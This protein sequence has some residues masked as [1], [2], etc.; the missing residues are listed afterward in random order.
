[1]LPLRGLAI[2]YGC[3]LLPVTPMD[4][5]RR[6][7]E[8]TTAAHLV[9][10]RDQRITGWSPSASVMLGMVEDAALGRHC[11]DVVRGRD[12]SGG[13][14]CRARCPAIQALREGRL[15]HASA[16]VMDGPVGAGPVACD[17]VALPAPSDGALITLSER[18]AGPPI[19]AEDGVSAGSAHLLASPAGDRLR[20]LAAVGSLAA[21]LSS[22]SPDRSAE[23]TLDWLRRTLDVEAS[24]VFLR[25]PGGQEMLLSYYRGPSA[26]A[27]EEISRFAIGEGY[28]GLVLSHGGVVQTNDLAHDSR[29]LRERV[30]SEGFRSYVCVP[31]CGSEGVIG[32][33][34]V[35]T[36]RSDL[37]PDRT[38][39]I[40]SW[41][42]TSLAPVLEAAS[43][44]ARLD[45]LSGVA[46]VRPRQDLDALLRQVLR[47]M[48]QVGGAVAGELALFAPDLRGTVSRVAEGDLREPVCG[49][50]GRERALPCP[51]VAGRHGVALSGPRES[52]APRC[53]RISTEARFVHCVPLI[54]DG[55]PVGLA[56]LRYGS[57]EPQ[58]ATRHLAVLLAIGVQAA[59]IVREARDAPPSVAAADGVSPRALPDGGRR[60][61]RQADPATQGSD[62]RSLQ[63]REPDEPFLDI[64]CFGS[65]ELMRQGRPVP[66]DAVRRRGAVTLLKVL[67]VNEGRPVPRDVMAEALWPG[68][69][70]GLTANRIYVLIHAL[71]RAIEPEQR[72]HQRRWAFI[73]S[74]GDRYYFNREAP[75]RC[76]VEEF[77]GHVAAGERLQLAG[78]RR[79]SMD[80]YAA[81]LDLYRGD[82]LEDE[83]YA[84][85]CWAEREYLRE[86]ALE[87]AAKLAVQHSALGAL[88]QSIVYFR[89]ALRID[90][91]REEIHRG[92]IETLLAAGRRAEA[93]REYAVCRDSLRRELGIDPQPET[94][95]LILGIPGGSG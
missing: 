13:A 46:G 1:M 53:Q 4:T 49:D 32:T 79:A 54:A 28:P 5:G 83:P 3:T 20:D 51:A 44:K 80:S 90:P 35:A 86:T 87:A 64:R 7:A 62:E 26:A 43:L 2:R 19:S 34:N 84:E 17:A 70:P 48:M 88:D 50:D 85:W 30:K 39:R 73:C 68:A 61:R 76:D 12:P 60:G 15:S 82:L 45:A 24:E 59:A 21:N 37:D 71:R 41:A 67:L 10:D 31:V 22:A 11:F 65:F 92:L 36:R 95:R 8:Q 52:W 42:S 16:M 78:D 74:D 93:V 91:L 66:P 23:Q 33:L 72:P 27:F 55:Q 69:D 58:P 9:I 75:Y 18:S 47:R 14:I 38:Q 56:R 77:R 81:A 29:Y 40:L 89:R 63:R 25:E 57:A 6:P 94:Q